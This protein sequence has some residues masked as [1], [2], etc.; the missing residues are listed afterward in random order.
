MTNVEATKHGLGHTGTLDLAAYADAAPV[1]YIMAEV[2]GISMQHHK[3]PPMPTPQ[4][5]RSRSC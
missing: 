4:Q 1:G 3:A 5:Q 2:E